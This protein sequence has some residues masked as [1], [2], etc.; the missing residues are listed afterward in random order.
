[1]ELTR[2]AAVWVGTYRKYNNGDLSG[3][4]I[5]LETNN[6]PELFERAAAA[7]HNDD[8]DPEIMIADFE[9][10]PARY[11]GESSLEDGV[12]QWLALDKQQREI[13]EAWLEGT[14]SADSFEYILEHYIGIYE[15]WNDFIYELVE[16]SGML[17]SFPLDV[18]QYFDYQSYAHDTE[19][20]GGYSTGPASS[21]GIH[22]FAN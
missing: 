2:D 7:L 19:I 4:W 17:D 16:G 8:P 5:S 21:G 1:M 18:R 20:G 11:Y 3:A 14:S 10:I 9:N 12:W 22:I 15:S 13:V 6:T